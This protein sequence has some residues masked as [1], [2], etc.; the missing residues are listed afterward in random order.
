MSQLPDEAFRNFL[1]SPF[2]ARGADGTETVGLEAILAH[3]A[4][5]RDASVPSH[6]AHIGELFA[7]LADLTNTRYTPQ[8]RAEMLAHYE[9]YLARIHLF[10]QVIRGEAILRYL[11][12]ARLVA[13]TNVPKTKLLSELVDERGNLLSSSVD[14]VIELS[15][16][17][18][19]NG[20]SAA[21]ANAALIR[22]LLMLVDATFFE[23]LINFR[24]RIAHGYSRAFHTGLRRKGK[25][26]P[27]DSTASE[28]FQQA[29]LM[30][31]TSLAENLDHLV[32]LVYHLILFFDSHGTLTTPWLTDHAAMKHTAPHM[33][34]AKWKHPYGSAIAALPNSNLRQMLT[35]PALA[36]ETFWQLVT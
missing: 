2:A 18:T 20:T 26:D 9:G 6:L 15:A 5:M 36:L 11:V 35:A 34:K 33:L 32:A 21:K 29:N 30:I 14:L 1:N 28:I 16:V 12:K 10:E 31:A 24:N 13:P 17:D 23:P 27:S 25:L 22:R 4:R 8:R 3:V 19:A 7:D